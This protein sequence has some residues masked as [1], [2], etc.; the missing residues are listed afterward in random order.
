VE[1]GG[2]TQGCTG[3]ARDPADRVIVDNP[4]PES[5]LSVDIRAQL[6]S[7]DRITK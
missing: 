7:F 1:A 6:S 2:V 5:Q 3:F 4:F